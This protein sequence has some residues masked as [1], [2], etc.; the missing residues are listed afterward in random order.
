VRC[1]TLT[2]LGQT[3]RPEAIT[4]LVRVAQTPTANDAS[5]KDRQQVRDCRLAAVRALG[6]YEHS[7]EG[8]DVMTRLLQT[9]EDVA[10]HDRAQAKMP[11]GAQGAMNTMLRIPSARIAAPRWGRPY[12]RRGLSS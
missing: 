5:D 8:G 3:K 12:R 10:L 7:R 6:N 1:L 4:Y 2:A 11:S 9:E